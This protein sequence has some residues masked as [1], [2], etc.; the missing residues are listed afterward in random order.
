LAL[1]S[2]NC[3]ENGDENGNDEPQ[4]PAAYHPLQKCG[5]RVLV[6]LSNV[7]GGWGTSA[8]DWALRLLV[9]YQPE[10]SVAVLTSQLDDPRR[11]PLA[12]QVLRLIGHGAEYVGTALRRWST[13]GGVTARTALALIHPD[14]VGP[15]TIQKVA[16]HLLNDERAFIEAEDY[17]SLWI[18]RLP[19][20]LAGVR[21]QAK[22]MVAA[23]RTLGFEGVKSLLRRVGPVDADAYELAIDLALLTRTRSLSQLLASTPEGTGESVGRWNSPESVEK[24]CEHFFAR[25]DPHDAESI[26]DFDEVAGV[27]GV[28]SDLR[29]PHLRHMMSIGDAKDARWAAIQLCGLG[30]ALDAA[31]AHLWAPVEELIRRLSSENPNE[32]SPLHP[33]WTP[34]FECCV[35]TLFGVEGPSE[36]LRDAVRIVFESRE[37]TWSRYEWYLTQLPES[38]RPVP[39]LPWALERLELAS[40]S[41]F[42]SDAERVLVRFDLPFHTE[43][44]ILVRALALGGDYFAVDRISKLVPES[45]EFDATDELL[46]GP[47]RSLKSVRSA[48]DR[49]EFFQWAEGLAS[50]VDLA[51]DLWS[52][53][54]LPASGL[55]EYQAAHRAGR[56]PEASLLWQLR[57]VSSEAEQVAAGGARVANFAREWLIHRIVRPAPQI[58]T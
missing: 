47:S 32:T 9:A 20:V 31:S 54:E 17:L 11:F 57:L 51:S 42:V 5:G 28:G 15:E 24:L 55:S 19:R 58:A 46:V 3:D 12:V 34:D 21:Q 22:E 6:E 53:A 7:N 4:H 36:R 27:L 44:K 37:L 56:A 41:E 30:V 26:G 14:E 45:S 13:A 35:S 10:R 23:G 29:E 33:D 25:W 50:R 39:T 18:P 43:F 52:L 48:A 40:S 49:Q 2:T 8:R 1:L 16:E 38:I